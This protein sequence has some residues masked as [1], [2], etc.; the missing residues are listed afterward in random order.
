MEYTGYE[1]AFVPTPP[2]LSDSKNQKSSEVE[3]KTPPK[4]S[5][6][7]KE[8]R[9]AQQIVEQSGEKNVLFG[10]RSISYHFT[11]A[12]LS[13]DYLKNPDKLRE[14]T[15]DFVIAKSGG[16]GI[17]GFTIPGAPTDNEINASVPTAN[18]DARDRR[19]QIKQTAVNDKKI[20]NI[21]LVR[22]FN[23]T[24]PGRFDLFIDQVE[25]D[26]TMTFTKEANVTLPTKLQFDILEPY[27][28][29]GFIE[30]LHVAA[31]AAGFTSYIN[32]PFV[33]KVEFW[34]YPDNDLLD[35]KD[36]VKIPDSERYFPFGLTG[37]EV[38]V[39]ERGTR[40]KCN[41][42][43]YEQR[44]MGEPNKLKK[45]IK[46]S[47][48]SVSEI[49]T[50]FVKGLN[51][52]NTTMYLAAYK[53]GKA[54][55]VDEYKIKFVDWNETEGWVESTSGVLPTKK[56]VDLSR[57]NALY[58][59]VNPAESGIRSAYKEQGKR[60]PTPEEKEKAPASIK[61][62]PGKTAVH[63]QEGMNVNDVI[64]AVVRDSEYIR[65]ILK[66]IKKH[67]DAYGMVDY[68]QVRTETIV[69]DVQNPHLKRPAHIFTYVVSPYKIHYSKI[70]NLADNIINEKEL[71]KLSRREYNYFYTGLNVDV[72]SFKLN[73]NTLY[74]EAI[75]AA[76][77]QKD[78][79][80]GK[81]AAGNQNTPQAKQSSV[82]NQTA[83]QL[84]VPLN[85][86]QVVETQI[87]SY[88]GTASQPLSDPYSELARN[89]HNAVVNSKSNMITADIEIAGDPFYLVTGG[90]GNYNPKPA[91]PGKLKGGEASFN[92][93]ALMITVNFRNPI[94]ILP[95]EQGGTMYFD[96]NRIPFSG[97]YMV[98]Q[99]GSSFRD[100]R[101][102]QKLSIVRMPGQILD[103][104]VQ[105]T[106]IAQ[107]VSTEPDPKNQTV[108]DANPG[109]APAAR[110]DSQSV[111]TQLGR[112]IP[113][114]GRPFETSNF[115][116]NPGSLGG[117]STSLQPQ[118]FGLI[119]RNGQLLSNASA[120][121]QNI[122][123][124]PLSNIRLNNNGL[125]SLSQTNLGTAAVV[126]VAANVLTGNVPV[127]R[128]VGVL[129]GSLIGA[130]LG[131]LLNKSNVGS[132]IGDGAT[133]KLPGTSVPIADATA[134]DVKQGLTI[135]NAV[136][137]ASS[138]SPNSA[139]KDLSSKELETVI[140]I[141]AG[142]SNFISNVKNK[143]KL[144][145]SSPADPN[146]I[147]AQAGLDAAKMSGLSPNLQSKLSSQVSNYVKN[148]PADTD[149]VQ[150][151]NSGLV[152]DY[153][154]ASKVKNLPAT[155]PYA[156]A[157]E[158]ITAAAPVALATALVNRLQSTAQV[159]SVDRTAA[160]DK[161]LTAQSQLSTIN[162]V[163]VVKDVQ[164]S[165]SVGQT[166]GSKSA[167]SPLSKLVQNFRNNESEA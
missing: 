157:P 103:Y 48:S 122:S 100:G 65:D 151:H 47:G 1:S 64:S 28:I 89:L 106:N 128:A 104:N 35:F 131:S 114:S 75:P 2:S 124:D 97:V 19:L 142:A 33:L 119:G 36:P 159:N 140:G 137:P 95:L 32:A 113:N 61:Y 38:E 52:Q 92:Q 156:T 166:F 72:L 87:Q 74:F 51:E 138:L 67:T 37:V 43:P 129:A 80:D 82:D 152:L 110:A 24:S 56:L 167:Q 134:Q 123:T 133:L 42:V 125:S 40:Y 60:Q 73:F 148:V 55:E 136:L 5:K 57:D 62:I 46:M 158:P 3:R 163:S 141:G 165:S 45:P 145:I 139:I 93:Q 14:S 21:E 39:T 17:S 144:E 22:N 107:S 7:T 162:G 79:P 83:S 117:I 49:L 63:F 153:I 149:L 59:M 108:A 23:T 85:P 150:A 86:K 41:G 58:G 105:A 164:N 120:I 160:S 4:D 8:Q 90:M 99:C 20:E 68:F 146:G 11:L 29:N 111:A 44:Y 69:T 109:L 76:L 118:T 10:Y 154:P 98:T 91:G 102:T 147:S 96:A 88:S 115:T 121:S 78:Q 127:K 66:D 70:P 16:K 13:K 34:G 53:N 30:A 126:A 143:T 12:G 94:D 116:D 27:S 15:L 112:S 161:I 135:N 132:G 77:G 6:E 130:K 50:N 18:D 101:F 155:V 81:T 84:Q 71:K 54:N 9:E 26:T 25:I 31:V